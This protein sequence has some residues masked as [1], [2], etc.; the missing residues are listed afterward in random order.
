M[1][2]RLEEELM[3]DLF[4]EDAEGAAEMLEEGDEFEDYDAFEDAE[5]EAEEEWEGAEE[6][7]FE[8]EFEGEGFEEFEGYGDDYAEEAEEEF[9]DAM[10]YA[11]GAEDTDEF[12]GKV[13][14]R[15]KRVAGR[16][17][18][19]VGRVARRV[20]PI[21]KWIPGPWG[22][23]ASMGLGLL[24]RLRAE[25]ATEEEALEAFAELA[26][27]NP[28]ARPIVAGLVAR[29]LVKRKGARLP[30]SIRKKMVKDISKAIKTLTRTRGKRAVRAIVPITKSVKRTAIAKRTPATVRAKILKRAAMKVAKSPK[31]IKKLSK[32]SPRAKAVVAR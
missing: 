7:Y 21:A 14:S 25:G 20:S 27:K 12:L 32:P 19:V 30:L 23:V 28:R 17:G 10:A 4:Y 5:L 8:D 1:T 22:R 31:L 18:R 2:E 6:D 26:A 9:E 13:F 24:G 11:L 29:T 3:D 16:V 15:I